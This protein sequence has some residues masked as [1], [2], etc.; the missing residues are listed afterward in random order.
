MPA[1]HGFRSN[2]VDSIAEHATISAPQSTRQRPSKHP[3]PVRHC[4][5]VVQARTGTG[6][7]LSASVLHLF[8]EATHLIRQDGTFRA[9]AL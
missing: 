2:F 9:S 1:H 5:L 3:S 8:W 7:A 6:A 4:A